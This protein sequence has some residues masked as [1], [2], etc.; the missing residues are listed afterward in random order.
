[1]VGCYLCCLW[2]GL[3]L[4]D[5]WLLWVCYS[6]YLIL[7]LLSGAVEFDCLIV[8]AFDLRVAGALVCILIAMLMGYAKIGDRWI[9]PWVWNC[10]CGFG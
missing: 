9:L 7:L 2:L 1:M 3:L 8:V 6:W 5:D 10:D 4:C